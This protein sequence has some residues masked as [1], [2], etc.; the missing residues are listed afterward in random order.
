MSQLPTHHRHVRPTVDKQARTSMPK[1]LDVNPRQTMFYP[2]FANILA[3]RIR[4]HW[5]TIPL[6]E[7][8]I[9]VLIRIPQIHPKAC[10][11][12][13]LASKQRNQLRRESNLLLG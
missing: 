1:P 8:E 2:Q 3:Q 10:L 13:L 4:P 9:T 5:G 12:V 6:R 11:L 7:Y